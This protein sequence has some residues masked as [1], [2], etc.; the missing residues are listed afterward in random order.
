VWWIAA[1]TTVVGV[2]LTTAYYHFGG[3]RSARMMA[4]VNAS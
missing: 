3:W 1:L 4:P 2:V